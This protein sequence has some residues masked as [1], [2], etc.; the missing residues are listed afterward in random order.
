MT[1]A[2]SKTTTGRPDRRH[3]DGGSPRAEGDDVDTPASRRGR[4]V[5]HGDHDAKRDDHAPPWPFQR[6]VPV[7]VSVGAPAE[8][9]TVEDGSRGRQMS[10]GT[11]GAVQ[12]LGICGSCFVLLGCY[13]ATSWF[14]PGLAVRRGVGSSCPREGGHGSA[15]N[16]TRICLG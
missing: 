15:E 7:L 2:I 3:D 11:G 14:H 8:T 9:T 10:G 13:R 5:H 6:A 16:S 12:V 4:G 1:A